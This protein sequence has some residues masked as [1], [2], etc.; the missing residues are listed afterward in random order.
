MTF[1]QRK[2]EMKDDKIEYQAG[3][4]VVVELVNR[5]GFIVLRSPSEPNRTVE[6]PTGL[7]SSLAEGFAT[8]ARAYEK[9]IAER[10]RQMRRG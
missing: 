9:E 4:E 2:E 8:I 5:G 7:L 6:I 1:G 3:D 10:H